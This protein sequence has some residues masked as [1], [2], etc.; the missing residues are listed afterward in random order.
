MST[1]LRYKLLAHDSKKYNGYRLSYMGF[2]ILALRTLLARNI[3]ASVGSQIGVGKESDIFEAQTEEGE[4]VV[5]KLHRLGRT[6]FRSVRK[7]RDY[8][9]GKNKTSW[10]YMSRL[11]AVREYA[12][13]EALHRHGFPTPVPLDQNRHVVCMSKVSGF[14][15]AQIKS[16][17]MAGAGEIFDTCVKILIRLAESGLVH[18]DFNEFNLMVNPQGKVTLIDFPQMVST[19]HPNA[20]ELFAR[21]FNGLV[22]FFAMKMRFIPT[23]TVSLRDITGGV[24]ASD[25]VRIDEEVRGCATMSEQESEALLNF[26]AEQAAD[27]GAGSSDDDDDDDET[28]P[29]LIDDAN[30]RAR[31]LHEENPSFTRSVF[32]FEHG[33]VRK[34]PNGGGAADDAEGGKG[35]WGGPRG[36]RRA[37]AYSGD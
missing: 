27:G 34:R 16:G 24:P 7:N 29:K 30:V 6:S 36:E 18:C 17:H 26:L 22:K 37:I 13:M 20:E 1:L 2:D 23:Q 28:E 3:I 21:D 10:L 31:A 19:T 11:A 14:P 9:K 4:E 32:G 25:A 15:M 33:E 5:V 12:F 8:M 35:G